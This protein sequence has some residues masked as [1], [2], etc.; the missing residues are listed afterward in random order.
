MSSNLPDASPFPFRWNQEI[1]FTG[2]KYNGFV[3]VVQWCGETSAQVIVKVNGDPFEVIEDTKFMQDNLAWLS[4]K[5]KTE[6]LLR[7]NS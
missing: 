6:L 7:P 1:R 3:G 2:G 5:S 4:S